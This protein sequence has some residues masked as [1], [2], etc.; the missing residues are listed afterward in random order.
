MTF[1]KIE[2]SPGA[3][4]DILEA[5][6]WYNLQQK[7]LGKRF[8]DDLEATITAIKSNPFHAS[9]KFHNIRTASLKIFPYSVHFEIDELEKTIRILSIFHFS[10]KPYW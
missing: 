8:G 3:A 10:R 5:K 4:D 2:F 1:F 7:G 6:L 9:I